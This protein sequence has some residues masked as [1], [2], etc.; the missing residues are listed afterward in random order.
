MIS[1]CSRFDVRIN[2]TAKQYHS[3]INMTQIIL[4]CSQFGIR[5]NTTAFRSQI[6]I[7]YFFSTFLKTL[8][9]KTA[10]R[11]KKIKIPGKI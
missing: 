7:F 1:F 9:N 5:I 4:F 11:P 10:P 2:T 3:E 6:G 8:K